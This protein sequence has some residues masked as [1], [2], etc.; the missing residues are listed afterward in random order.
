M[1]LGP[2]SFPP[3]SCHNG[4][5]VISPTALI[6]FLNDALPPPAAAAKMAA[7]ADSGG[8]PHC[9]AARVLRSD[10]ALRAPAPPKVDHA[11]LRGMVRMEGFLALRKVHGR[12]GPW[13]GGLDKRI[14]VH[15]TRRP[16]E[17]PG[18]PLARK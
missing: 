4:N 9:Q 11:A 12:E 10:I 15:S 16:D 7:A 14:E 6:N 2:P 13:A 1:A 17:A 18:S 8:S 3:C 5:P